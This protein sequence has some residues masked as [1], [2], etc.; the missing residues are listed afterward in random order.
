MVLA[1]KQ[2][3]VDLLVVEDNPGDVRLLEEAFR[4]LKADIRMLVAKDGAEAVEMIS[5]ARSD[6]D[7]ACL[8]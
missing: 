7:R 4:E 8:I 3:P 1:E 5:A 6:S 2:S